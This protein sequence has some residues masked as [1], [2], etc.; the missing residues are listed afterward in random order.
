M[1]RGGKRPGA[2][3]K[4]SE[5][6]TDAEQWWIQKRCVRMH[7]FLARKRYLRE[8]LRH[9][10]SYPA[11]AAI[12]QTHERL[13]SLPLKYTRMPKHTT[14]DEHIEDVRALIEENGTPLFSVKRPRPYDCRDQIIER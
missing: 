1:P 2:G 9:L 7:R 8:E 13:Q 14:R 11:L 5:T 6:L 12:T 10:D 3:R 4:P